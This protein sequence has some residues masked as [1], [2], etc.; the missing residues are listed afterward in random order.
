ME[1][2]SKYSTI[3]IQTLSLKEKSPKMPAYLKVGDRYFADYSFYRF[4]A[5]SNGFPSPVA[6]LQQL[7]PEISVILEAFDAN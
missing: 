6:L 4:G 7:N 5:K 1:Y 2:K 3:Q